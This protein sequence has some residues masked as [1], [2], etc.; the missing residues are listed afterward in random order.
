MGRRILNRKEMRADFDAAEQRRKDE[1]ET[2][3]ET[4]EETEDETDELWED[5]SAQI[6]VHIPLL[7][8]ADPQHSVSIISHTAS[9]GVLKS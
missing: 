3:E 1:E 8:T 9:Q 2:E 5:A 7:H 6:P 4:D